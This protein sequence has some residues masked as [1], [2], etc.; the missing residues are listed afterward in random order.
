[1]FR[2]VTVV[3]ILGILSINGFAQS[4]RKYIRRGNNAFEEQAYTKSEINYRK[5]V[6][7]SPDSYKAVYNMGDA[8]Y[9]QGKYQDVAQKFSALTRR[10][11]SDDKMT[12]V[13]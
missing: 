1:M 11:L 12:N 6:E 7:K 4:E 3:L 9:K 2:K 10:D 13:Y 8:L 5:A